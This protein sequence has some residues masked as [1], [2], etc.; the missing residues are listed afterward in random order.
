[1]N[2]FAVYISIYQQNGIFWTV[3]LNMNVEN[4]IGYRLFLHLPWPPTRTVSVSSESRKVITWYIIYSRLS[5]SRSPRDSLEYFEISV[6]R[7]IRFA[8]LRKLIN[9]T[10]T[11]NKWI[12]NLTPEVNRYTE[13]IVE[14]RRNC[15]ENIVEKRRNCSLERITPPF[16]NIFIPVVSFSF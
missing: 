14:K 7:H 9:R 10:T 6:P 11:F 3:A 1:M 16:Y 4:H 12:C 5:L 2:N 15:S 8:E 13:K